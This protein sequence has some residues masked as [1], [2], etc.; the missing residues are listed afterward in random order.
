M[1]EEVLRVSDV[2][3]LA[4]ESS[5]QAEMIYKS[6]LAEREE[7]YSDSDFSSDDEYLTSVVSGPGP[8]VSSQPLPKCWMR[9]EEQHI[10]AVRKRKSP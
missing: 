8:A 5:R 7:D 4:V 9:W 3:F 1:Y 10:P 2:G 6:M